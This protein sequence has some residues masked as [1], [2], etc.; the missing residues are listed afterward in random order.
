MKILMEKNR[1]SLLSSTIDQRN[2]LVVLDERVQDLETLYDALLPGV[3]AH[4]LNSQTDAITTISQLLAET[5]ATKLAIAAHGE[6]GTIFLGKNPLN[7]Q[8][9]AAYSRLL[10]EWGVKEIALYS[11]QV[12]QGNVGKQFIHQLSELTGAVI[13]ASATKTGS[14]ELGGN[15]LLEMTTGEIPES[16]AF[17]RS[18]LE[19]YQGILDRFDPF[20]TYDTGVNPIAVTL[21]DFNGD[22]FLDIATAKNNENVSLLLNNGDGTFGT[23]NFTFL[24]IGGTNPFAIAAGDFNDD[25]DLDLVTANRNNNSVSVLIGNG[26]GGF[27]ATNFAAG[28]NPIDVTVG[29]FNN[30]GNLD[31]AT[32]KDAASEVSLLLGNGNGTFG[33]ASFFNLNIGGT[34]PFAIAAG[35]FNNDG[36][37]DLVTANRNNNSVSVLIGNG[38]G[39]FTPTNFNAGT[40]PIDV[41]VGDFDN[42]G[43]LDIATAKDNGNVSVLFGNGGGAFGGIIFLNTTGTPSSIGVGDFNNDGNLDIVTTSN[44]NNN[45]SLL[46][47]NGD[48]TFES[49][50]TFAV[51]SGPNSIAV[52]DLTNNT[53]SDVVTVSQGPNTASVLIN[54][55]PADLLNTPFIRFQ[56]TNQPGTYLF[57]NQVE[58]A[59]IR[60]NPGLRQFVEEGV[61][62]QVAQQKTDPLQQGFF[63]FQNTSL[64]GTYLFANEG[65]AAAIR[66]N[67]NLS[68]FVEEGLAF[69]AYGPGTGNGTADFTR[70]QSV[71]VPGTYLFTAPGETSSVIGNPNFVREGIAFS[72]ALG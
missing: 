22:G 56:N 70:F 36:N 20:I 39:G 7:S 27:T 21:G 41:T 8:Q 5:G 35:D 15:W 38:S 29:D 4:T 71:G 60:N 68:N 12:A 37:L 43:N 65:E 14:K 34:D 2:T 62:F 32:V 54:D 17:E 16:L 72:A 61:A 64:P 24:S 59:A 49:A 52:G 31:I 57:V 30:D 42:D 69:Y 63:R 44:S 47:G 66:S 25:G 58:A 23:P 45:V 1:R 51:D 48:R 53:L 9:L 28:S 50:A 55:N 26:N 46:L 40:N 33:G 11:C 67:P 6:P 10:M 18:H 19:I 13:A 3:V